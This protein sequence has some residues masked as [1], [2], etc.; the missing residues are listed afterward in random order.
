M[1]DDRIITYRNV[2]SRGAIM[3]AIFGFLTFS[4]SLFLACVSML[5]VVL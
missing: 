3:V 4:W 5:F 1:L 2:I